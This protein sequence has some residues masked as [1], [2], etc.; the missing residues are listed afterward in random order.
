MWSSPSEQNE[1]VFAKALC[2]RVGTS[3]HVVCVCPGVCELENERC[4]VCA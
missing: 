4:L 3:E 2:E 1:S